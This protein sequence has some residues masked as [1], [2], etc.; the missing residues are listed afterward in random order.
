MTA[1]S[2]TVRMLRS[3]RVL[4]RARLPGEL[5]RVPADIAAS[6]ASARLAEYAD[7]TAFRSPADRA[8]SRY[9]TRGF[10]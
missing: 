1:P 8:I 5:V 2:V 7:A 6:L 10:L 9:Y 4:R 3:A